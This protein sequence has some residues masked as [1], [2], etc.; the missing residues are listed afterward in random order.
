MMALDTDRAAAQAALKAA[1]RKAVLA[2]RK[3]VHL[4]SGAAAASQ[5][6]THGLAL[7]EPMSGAVVSGYLPIRN[8]LDIVP[9][10]EALHGLGRQIALPVIVDR[11]GPLAF[12]HWRPGDG[13]KAA[14][15]GLSEPLD[16]ALELLPDILL[17]PLA[18]FDGDGTRLGYGGGYYDRTL[19]LYRASRPVTAIGIAYDEQAVPA[20]PRE[21]HDQ[22]LDWILTPSG[23]RKFS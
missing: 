7:I 8:E 9:L 16:G 5:V 20:L 13:L 14:G 23:T 21:P 10:L 15:F 17:V 11:N 2:R 12:R 18:A 1:L 6:L 4:A 22:R 19:A 3:D